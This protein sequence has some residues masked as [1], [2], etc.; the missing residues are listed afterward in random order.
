VEVD[1]API[2]L[3]PNFSSKRRTAAAK[4][5]YIEGSSTR[6]EVFGRGAFPDPGRGS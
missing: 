4:R 1:A 3:Q 5:A 6:A 2:Q